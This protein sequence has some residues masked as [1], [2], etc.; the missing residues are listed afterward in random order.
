MLSILS[1]GGFGQ[2]LRRC[3]NHVGAVTCAA[4]ISFLHTATVNCL[5]CSNTDVFITAK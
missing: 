2:A 5:H 1:S 4:R 3:I